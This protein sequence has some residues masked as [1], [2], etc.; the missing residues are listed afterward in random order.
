M[1]NDDMQKA[2]R[3]FAAPPG[4]DKTV[5]ALGE[6]ENAQDGLWV[7]SEDPVEDVKTDGRR[8][9][10][11]MH[12]IV[13][14]DLALSQGISEQARRHENMSYH[15]RGVQIQKRGFHFIAI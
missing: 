1:S 3:E 14:S 12:K 9:F 13:V 10:D 15:F 2:L 4:W 11:R 7:I 6:K 5:M 8:G